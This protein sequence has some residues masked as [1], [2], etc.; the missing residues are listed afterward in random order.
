M[1]KKNLLAL[2]IAV[3][4]NQSLAATVITTASVTVTAALMGLSP[5]VWGCATFG[6]GY[7]YMLRKDAPRSRLIH[8][9][10]SIVI[11]V[12]G[13][14]AAASYLV[15]AHKIQSVFLNPLLALLIAAAFPWLFE[16]YITKRK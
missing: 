12:F 1:I 16:K 3:I 15:N 11:A 14:D 13:S 5:W 9:V 10:V 4:H 6:A 2:L 7:A 8:M